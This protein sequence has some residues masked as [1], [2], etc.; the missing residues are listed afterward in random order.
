MTRRAHN[1]SA[2]PAALPTSV[3]E[4]LRDE[5]LDWG[6]LGMGMLEMS[7]RD[8]G[9]P[10]QEMIAG[11]ERALR[12]LLKVPDN[13]YVLFMHGGAHGQFAAAPMN[14]LGAAQGALSS[15]LVTGFW[16]QRALDE[17]A[18]YGR[19]EVVARADDR[20]I[21]TPD[22]WSVDPASAYIQLCANETIQ[23][24]ELHED[25]EWSGPQPLVADFTSTL[26][27]RPVD[28][29]RYGVIFASG[30]KNVGTA[31]VTVVIVRDDLLQREPHPALPSVFNYKIAANTEPIPSLYNTPPVCAIYLCG[32]VADD[33]VA[34]GGLDAM[35]ARAKRHADALYEIIDG[36]DGFYQNGVEPAYRSRMNVPFRILGG[37]VE[38]ERRFTQR[39]EECGLLQVFGHPRFGGQ[40]I[41][42]YNNIP[43]EAIDEVA[44]FM[45]DFVRGARA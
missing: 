41:T 26:L 25:P 33:L 42:L 28:I 22:R 16:S 11:A 4:R 13:Y 29:S 34:R 7:H 39:A 15:H 14:L 8:P 43:D 35:A 45:R 32:L 38:L 31:G 1:F 19:V 23:G 44:Q 9:G 10:V 36:S 40:R 12:A 24:L 6:G 21:P 18:R 20:S 5:L 17:A 2:G 37:D 30:G 3:L 27:S